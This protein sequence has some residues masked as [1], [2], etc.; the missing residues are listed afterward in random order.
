MI[1]KLEIENF[2]SVRER[3][4]IDLTVGKKVPEEPGRLVPIHDGSEERAP[5]L[6]AIYGANASGKSNVLRA[7]TFLSWF[8]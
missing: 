1:Y 6:I 2:Y 5:R 8:V 7:I 4:V 3:Q